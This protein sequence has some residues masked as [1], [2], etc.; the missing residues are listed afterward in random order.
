MNDSVGILGGV[1]QL[2]HLC[3]VETKEQK[4]AR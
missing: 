2:M 1:N 3:L 4:L